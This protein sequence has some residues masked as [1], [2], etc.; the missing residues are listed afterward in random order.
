[1]K[2]TLFFTLFS[3][4]YLA[5]SYAQTITTVAG[6][7]FGGYSGDGGPA[8]AAKLYFPN[9]VAVDKVGNVFV[10]DDNATVRKIN[11]SGII[12]T[13]AGIAD[14]AGYN[15]DNIPA[16]AAKLTVIYGLA[17]D[18]HNNVYIS[19]FSNHR[20]RKVDAAGIIT[21]FAG[22]GSVTP[23]GKGG[24]ATAAGLGT[25]RGI[26]FDTAGNLY[27]AGIEEVLKVDTSG[28]ITRY[29]G[30]GAV[31]FSGDGGAATNAQLHTPIGVMMDLNGNLYLGDDGNY[32]IRKV[33]SAGIITTIAGTGIVGYSGDGGQATAANLN[34]PSN[35]FPDNCG[36]LYIADYFN[37]RV[38]M[39]N[40]AGRISTIAGTGVIGYS[41]DGGPATSAMISRPLSVWLDSAGSIYIAAQ[42]NHSIRYIHMDSCRNTT[43]VGSQII[44]EPKLHVFPNPAAGVFTINISSPTNETAEVVITNMMGKTIK[45]FTTSTNKETDLNLNVAPGMYIVTATKVN[46]RWMDKVL[47]E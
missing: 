9:F 21:T 26:C 27:I 20:I 15:G 32:R 18:K 17:F 41:G 40:S 23:S 38:R 31:G 29:A 16:T 6:T 35:V 45:V 37:N 24:P 5:N 3:L 19:D 8:T 43:E 1:M 11:T 30:T 14:S 22:N 46:G 28:I 39:I 2:K 44:T 13:F 25:V 12:S 42:G 36:N 34:H 10:A 33:S 7:G 47:V 4:L